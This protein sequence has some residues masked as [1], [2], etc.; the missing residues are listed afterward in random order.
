MIA[1]PPASPPALRAV[2]VSDLRLLAALHAQCF[3]DCWTA[4]AMAEILSIPGSFALLAAFGDDADAPSAGFAIARVAAD[5]AE[6]LSIGVLGEMRRRGVGGMLLDAVI[7][8]AAQAGAWSVFLEVAEDNVAGRDLYA[9]RGFVAVGRRPDYYRP[10]GA[11][12]IA[13]LWS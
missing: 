12:P 3:D 10:R 5:E 7:A 13:A 2:G 4:D 9:T 6:L 11:A 8:R 1:P